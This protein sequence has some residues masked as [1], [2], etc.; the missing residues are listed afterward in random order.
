MDSTDRMWKRYGAVDPYFGVYSDERFRREA[1]SD[2]HVTEFF[3]SGTRDVDTLFDV[4]DAHVRKGFHPR[5]ALDYGCGVGRMAVPLAARCGQ[6]VAADV[7]EGMLDE[8]RANCEKRGV[9][10]IDAVLADDELTRVAGTFDLVH[11]YIVLQHI[12]PERGQRIL[13][14]LVERLEPGGVAMLHV[15]YGVDRSPVRRALAWARA[16]VPLVHNCANLVTGRSFSYPRMEITEYDMGELFAMLQR[17]GCEQTCV[18]LTKHAIALGAM[19]FFEKPAQC[20][21]A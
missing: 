3:E 21:P 6:V 15:T 20:P 18:R 19:L 2:R 10:N 14:R 12:E 4:I 13:A 9:R 5:R 1:L 8:L 7:S 11:S 16:H 17:H